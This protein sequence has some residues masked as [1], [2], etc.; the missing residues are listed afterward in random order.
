MA[1]LLFAFQKMAITRKINN[2]NYELICN[3][4]ELQR[5]QSQIGI[6]EQSK[7]SLQ[8]A[9]STASAL[10]SQSSSSIYQASVFASADD[11]TK[12]TTAYRE[13]CKNSQSSGTDKANDPEVIA[14]KAKMDDAQKASADATQKAYVGQQAAQQALAMTGQLANSVF[15]AGD[16]AKRAILQSQDQRLELRKGQ[17][18]SELS[19]LN[20]ELENVTKAET[21]SAKKTAPNFGLA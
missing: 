3:T 10:L 11:V 6:M 7:A 18:Q 19:L 9:W 2:K 12:A 21:D 13:A 5:I 8:D 20:N 15:E 17:I 1:F 4:N 14:A 16:K